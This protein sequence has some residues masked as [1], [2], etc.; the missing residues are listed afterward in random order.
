MDGG[1]R[2]AGM[3]LAALPSFALSCVLVRDAG[4]R[5][6]LRRL[7]C[8][9]WRAADLCE[10]TKV[11]TIQSYSW[12]S[13]PVLSTAPAVALKM[14]WNSWTGV[15]LVRVRPHGSCYCRLERR[16]RARRRDDRPLEGQKIKT[17][18]RCE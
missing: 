2:S 17:S 4:E 10:A 3:P 9:R 12:F 5:R 7:T 16:P 13:L 11:D 8:E 18:G 1:P 6:G 14:I 15:R